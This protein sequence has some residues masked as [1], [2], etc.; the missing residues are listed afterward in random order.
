MDN[1][2]INRRA[3]KTATGFFY[4][5]L[6]SDLLFLITNRHVVQDRNYFPNTINLTLHSDEHDMTKNKDY[7]IHLYNK[8]EPIWRNPNPPEADVVAI[9]IDCKDFASCNIE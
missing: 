5:N 8:T 2:Q 6:Q 4:H 1:G 7:L 9:P 3:L